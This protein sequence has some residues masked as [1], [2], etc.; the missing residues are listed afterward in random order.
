MKKGIRAFGIKM[1]VVIGCAL[2]CNTLH[3]QPFEVYA[4]EYGG[5]Q[6]SEQSDGTIWITE[7]IGEEEDVVLPTEIDGKL[8]T[9]I[10]SNP[11]RNSPDIEN[12]YVDENN[13][14][15]SSID[16][17]LYNKNI[18]TVLAVPRNKKLLG[19][20]F[21]DFSESD[22]TYVLPQTV[23]TIGAYAFYGY[24]SLMD[25][26]EYH[27]FEPGRIEIPGWV[28]TIEEHAFSG[29]KMRYLCIHEAVSIGAYAF[30][31]CKNLYTASLHFEKGKD[32]EYLGEGAFENCVS[33]PSI[34]IPSPVTRIESRTFYGCTG[35][36][37]VRLGKNLKSIGDY[38]FYNCGL[39]SISLP[40]SLETIGDYAFGNVYMKKTEE[41]LNIDIVIPQ[42]VIEIGDHAFL[43]IRNVDTFSVSPLNTAYSS[44]DGVLYG[45][46]NGKKSILIRCPETKQGTCIISEEVE[47]IS[48]GAFAQ[49]TYLEKIILPKKLQEIGA[50][51]FRNCSKLQ[52]ILIPEGVQELK[53][54]TF[55]GC[56]KLVRVE[57][58]DHISVI[59]SGAFAGCSSMTYF[60]IPSKIRV[61]SENTFAGCTALKSI[62]IPKSVMDIRYG[63]FAGCISLNNL[64]IPDSTS[65]IGGRAFAG[66]VGL[67]RIAIPDSVRG[68]AL[69]VED[70]Y[71]ESVFYG[72]ESLTVYCKKGSM[73]WDYAEKQEIP[74][75][76]YEEFFKEKTEIDLPE[77]NSFFKRGEKKRIGN[78]IYLNIGN[79][80]VAYLR[81]VN[82]MKN[83]ISLPSSVSIDGKDYLVWKISN[84]AFYK[85]VKLKK[86]IIS[87]NIRIIENKAFYNCNKLKKIIIKTMNLKKVGKKAFF[88]IHKR[89]IIQASEK[90]RKKYQKLLKGKGMKTYTWMKKRGKK[91]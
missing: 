84:K 16:G 32:L 18:D 3:E 10:R 55:A 30:S 43:N 91:K 59:G 81:P 40:E 58:A 14:F 7:Y 82:R 8:V 66:C 45:L 23:N 53:E 68:L 56:D 69:D 1:L 6:Y 89:P 11:F 36:E 79:G 20:C 48:E 22:K 87:K 39:E 35:L 88:G 12:I 37:S 29:A 38:A 49:C 52:N 47:K 90:K 71:E 77:M 63:A 24:N 75:K 61:I 60:Y 28:T 65:T 62:D 5:F 72:C 17:V 13:E 54:N 74:A 9:N 64:V 25:E 44:E 2:W 70:F 50:G 33:L 4:S 73:V 34:A 27:N 83:T 85:C 41:N 57:L 51:A 46:R 19:Y 78:G 31:D 42:H 67:Q 86:V 76:P 26:A 80:R 15:F 21:M